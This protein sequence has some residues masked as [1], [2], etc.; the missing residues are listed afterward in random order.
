MVDIGAEGRNSDGGVF[1][2][3]KLSE[4]LINNTLNIPP[5][6]PIESDGPALPYVLVDDEAFGLSSYMMR[7]YPV[8]APLTLEKK[9]YNYRHSRAR[10]II[11][12]AFG[13]LVN[14]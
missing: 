14:R 12:C 7:P 10:R 13:I 4:V 9:V 11:E 6:V 2:R 8:R 1:M 5:P 3:S